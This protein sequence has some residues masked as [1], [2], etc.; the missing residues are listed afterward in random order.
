MNFDF[1][2]DQ[3][4]FRDSLVRFLK[5]KW[6]VK[7]VRSYLAG[8]GNDRALWAG[9][10]EMGF[11]GALVPE[12]HGGLGLT[13]I[14]VV[15]AFEE[16]GRALV[17]IASVETAIAAWLIARHGNPDQKRQLLPKI[18]AGKHRIALAH[19]EVESGY[20]ASEIRLSVR[21]EGDTLRLNGTKILVPHA[22]T[23]DS[24]LVS[25]RAE[26]GTLVLVLRDRADI[27]VAP[28]VTIDASLPCFEVNF[29]NAAVPAQNVLGEQAGASAVGDM[30][31]ASALAAAAMATGIASRALDMAVDYA[32]TRVQFGRVIGSF[33]A[34]KH[35]CAD[36]A[37]AL[38]GARSTIYYAAWALSER[39]SDAALAVSLAKAACGD[40]SRAICNES[41][42]VH[43][44]IGFTW[45]YDL[46]L[47]MK[48]A[49]VHESVHGNATWHRERIAELILRQ[50]SG[51]MAR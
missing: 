32:K 11:Y 38:D 30:T 6:S 23:A 45:E 13:F 50:D 40:A 27:V 20:H 18:A 28:H 3:L 29:A 5:D 25:A 48:R 46:H 15:M 35:K 4:Q 12:E 14:D 31:D 1:S 43:G 16:F 22:D 51:A 9:L 2:H 36:M 21:K 41:L 42:Q 19:Q 39:S 24:L 10:A 49:K 34:V 44:G 26:A 33:Q 17:T 8:V 37:V 7:D 47:Y